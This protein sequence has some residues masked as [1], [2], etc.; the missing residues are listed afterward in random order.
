MNKIKIIIVV[1]AICLASN[2]IALADLNTGLVAYFP[3]NGNANDESSNTNNGTVNGA[4]LVDDRFGNPSS[5]YQFDCVDDYIEI[6]NSPSV[7]IYD[8]LTVLAWVKADIG[9]MIVNKLTYRNTHGVRTGWRIKTGAGTAVTFGVEPAPNDDLES[10]GSGLNVN[11]G[12]WHQVGFSW[13]DASDTVNV[14]VDG[15]IV[16]SY[17]ETRQINTNTLPLNIGKWPGLNPGYYT[18]IIDDIRIYN[19]VLSIADVDEDYDDFHGAGGGGG[20]G[21]GCF[22]STVAR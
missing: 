22:I 9:G 20:G 3:F 21:G 10:F 5:A 8:T 4:T 17:T 16:A 2:P 18:G 12:T 14:I 15:L 6:P 19:R 11:D 1:T 7:N 13:D